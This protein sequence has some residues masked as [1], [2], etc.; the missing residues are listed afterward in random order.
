[1]VRYHIVTHITLMQTSQSTFFWEYSE[2]GI[3]RIDGI[4]V[5]SERER[6]FNK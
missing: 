1:M 2:M 6:E 4:H 5:F 3:H